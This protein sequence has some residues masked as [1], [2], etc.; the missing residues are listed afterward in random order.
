VAHRQGHSQILRRYDPQGRLIEERFVDVAGRPVISWSAGA[1]MTR[2]A[3]DALG[4][5][6]DRSYFGV[7]GRPML[8]ASGVA[9]VRSRFDERGNQ[10]ELAAFGVDGKPKALS[11]GPARWTRTFD[12]RGNSLEMR[13]F[14]VDGQPVLSSEGIAVGRNR[15]DELGR[16]V[17]GAAFGVDGKPAMWINEKY[18]RWTAKFDDRG[19]IIEENYF[20]V[21]GKPTVAAR[22]VAGWRATYDGNGRKVEEQSYGVDGKPRAWK[23]EGYARWTAKYDARGDMIEVAHFDVNGKPGPD[24]ALMKRIYDGAGRMIE[25]TYFDA[26]GRPAL[27]R[28]AARTRR[29]YDARGRRI[30]LSYHGVDDRPVANDYGIAVVRD[31]HDARDNFVE[32]RLFDVAGK[33]VAHGRAGWAAFQV[34][35]GT[36]NNNEIRS[37]GLDLRGELVFAEQRDARGTEHRWRRVGTRLLQA[38]GDYYESTGQAL[39]PARAIR[40]RALI[41]SVAMERRRAGE[42][43]LF[44]GARGV[45]VID[46]ATG[47]AGQQLGVRPGDVLL[48]IGGRR[49]DR[50]EDVQPALD[51]ATDA[52]SPLVLLRA[53]AHVTVQA[54]AGRGDLGLVLEP[55]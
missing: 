36:A 24:F 52:A 11:W 39:D 37:V 44:R 46:V 27:F 26:A 7:N 55:Q 9:R 4:N 5:E 43:A 12:D 31:R 35:Y 40:A 51:A 17:E 45:L 32:Q 13:Y 25:E 22:G 10:L 49:L 28:G 18:A 30:A 47:G 48:E 6:I 16:K 15:Y 53:G 8:G 2:F 29:T 54:G 21:D 14:G 38:E 3:Y 42:P 50:P 34:V 19:N 23:D 20:G 41:A 33:P 1:A